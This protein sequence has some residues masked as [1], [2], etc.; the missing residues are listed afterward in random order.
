M[1]F[2]ANYVTNNGWQA[3]ERSLNL[4]LIQPRLFVAQSDIGR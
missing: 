1:S 4:P 3:I 2:G